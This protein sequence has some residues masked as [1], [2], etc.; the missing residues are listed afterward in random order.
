M[1]RRLEGSIAA[2]VAAILLANA[3]FASPPGAIIS[4]QASLDYTNV[5]GL[6]VTI[7]SNI[8]ELTTAVVRSPANVELTRVVG[9]GSGDYQETTGP[10]ACFQGGSFVTLAD[11]TLIGG[12]TIDPT[13][14]QDVSPTSAYNLG[15]AAFIRLADTDQNL[16]FQVIDYAVVTVENAASGDSEIIRLAETGPDTGVFAGY[17]PTSGGAAVSGDC[18]LQVQSNSTLTVDYADP[19][20]ATDTASVSATIDPVQRVFESRT[21]TLVDG[22][23]IELVDA[24]TGLPAL[25]YGNDGV[26]QFPSLIVS[27]GSTVDSGGTSYVFGN[28]EY[29]FPVVPD[30]DYRLIVT[31]PSDYTA[32]S[33]ADINDLQ[34]LPGAPFALE[35]GSF[36]AAFS[37][38]GDLSFALDIPVD[39]QA[40]A[41]FLQKRT[42]TTSAAPG[43]FV[44]YELVLENASVSGLANN[45]QIFDDLPAGVRLV[46]GSVRIDDAS[47]AD[48]VISADLSQLE[49]NIASLD[50]A[51]R[52]SIFYV[53]E[54]IGG[55]RDQELINR[56]T[57]FA[58]GGLIS[59]EATA[60][61]RLKE[62]LFRSTGTI[63]GRIVE[64][65]CRQES[66]SEDQGVEN[67]RVYLEDGRY[68]VSD[69]GGRFHFEG[70]EP[71]T[72]VAQ[73]DTFTV[74]AYFDVIGCD[75]SPGFAGNVTSQFVKL[76]RGSLLR[77]DFYLKRKP[78]PEGRIDLE[79]RNLGTDSA[80]EVAYELTLNG[81]GNVDIQ[82]IDLMFLLPDGV[83]YQ[84]GS[85]R[86]DGQ[87]HGDPRVSGTMLS[88]AVDDKF[89][90]WTS[91]VRFVAVIDSDVDGELTTKAMAKFDSPIAAGQET[92]VAE[93]RMSREPAETKNEGYVLDLKFA[94]LSDELSAGDKVKL[95]RLIADWKG[96]SDIRIGAIGHSD[97][98]RIAPRNRHL[99]ADNYA[100]SEAR[101][102]AAARYLADALDIPRDNMQIAGRGPDEPLASNATAAGRQANRRVEMVLSGV[103]PSK[104]SFLEVTQE[105]S[106]TKVT[107]T[108]G[109]IP[110][111]EQ[112]RRAREASQ[113][114]VDAGLPTSQIEPP[115]DT[116]KPGVALLLPERGFQPAIPAT[117]VSVQHAP[118][119]SVKIYINDAPINPLSFDVMG[120][121]A[122]RTVAV[123]RWK[124]V[125]LEDGN[126]EIRV[127]VSNA[128]GSRAKS[129]TRDVY[130]SGPAVR[131][132]FVEELSTLTA[133]GKTR[134]VIAVRLFDRAGK[135][136][137][138]GTVG[139]YRVDAPYRSI[140]DVENDRKNELVS[141]GPREPVY[142]VGK[143]GIALIELEP[144]TQSGEVTL[145]LKFER[146]REQQMRAWLKPAAR[147]WIL[148][149]FAEG[150]AA[151]N[152]L[153]KNA[154]LAM[155]AGFEDEYVDEGRVA[156]F[157]K[158]SIK[159]EYLMTI[160][161]DSDR[162][163]SKSRN[164]FETEVDPNA[165]YALYAD[166]SEQRFEAPSQRKLYVK[167][168]RNQF[169]AL[170]GDM[171]TGLSITDLARYER[172]FNGFKS[173]F[174]GDNVGYTVFAAE[175][176][177]GF[178][179]DELRGDGTSGLYR[180][181]RTP[182]IVSSEQVRIEV[183]DRFDSG[184]VLSETKLSRFVDYNLDTLNGTLFFK[185]PVP[186]RDLDFNP[187]FIVVEYESVSNADEDLIAGGRISVKSDND[188]FEVGATHVTDETAGAEADLSGVDMR[189][190]INPETLLKVE[191]A[192]SNSIDAGV[193]LEGTAH[194]VE[195][196]HNGEN[197]D[198]RAYIREVEDDFGLG[199]QSASDKGFRRLGVEA[200]GRISER[201][202]YEGEAGWQQNLSTE[203]IR[204]LASARLRYERESFSAFAGMLH[205]A[206]KFD[207]GEDRVSDI[208]QL[209]ISKKLFGGKLNL[210]ASGSS[211]LSGETENSDFPTSF[212]V[213]ADYSVRKGV[214][215]VAEYE[216][217]SG[218]GI[219]ATMTRVGVKANPWSRTQINTFVTNE[220]SE[221]GPRLFANV[222]LVQGFQLSERW[223]LDFGVDQSNT[224][225]DST[226]R[227]F[228]PD[229]DLVSGS[230]NED[231]LAV[232]AG[233]MYTADVWSANSR[234]EHRNSDTE[235]RTSLLMGWYREPTVGH[236][237]SAGLTIL[238]SDNVSGSEL[239]AADLKVGWAYRKANSR[240][241]FLNRTDLT[242]EDSLTGT[243]NLNS[244]RVVN[245]FNANRRYG[246]SMQLSLQYAF[247]YVR[248]EFDNDGYNGFT[249]LIGVDLRRGMR[250]RWDVGLYTSIYHSYQSSVI[251]Y[252]VGVDVGYQLRD[253]MWLTLGYNAA[254]FHD[255]DFSSARYTAQGPYLRFSI[256]ADQAILKSIAGR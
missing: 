214:D 58:D 83:R 234:L 160:A 108:K 96:V 218:S 190:Q 138:A 251:D 26:S 216:D 189:W 206:D 150:T 228:D 240:W 60:M 151:Y 130:Y 142:R 51:E 221:F 62:D 132:E 73:L 111:E 155:E 78:R 201:W 207:D 113:V 45:V 21:G 230:N 169:N 177:Q 28:G 63:L 87:D 241:S 114:D 20:D 213:G 37:K 184:Q 176:N 50:V 56:A 134:P 107:P 40:S 219:D 223:S 104:P 131:G 210:R 12:S 3:A 172:R 246:A 232:F 10:S 82:N 140:W 89:G 192:Q 48:P 129:I 103:R 27:G 202:S 71:G 154:S 209:G 49:F 165:L 55:E 123:S 162:D 149:G 9:A 242:F 61:I 200:R 197:V 65:D 215:L 183:R 115:I 238:T 222:G 208:G 8:V 31:P 33:S 252:G 136:S 32:P 119:Q 211:A 227:V 225:S 188:A 212:V 205:A 23:E 125:A 224:L 120:L 22:A 91:Q 244:W 99:F 41:L 204:N 64:G 247:K 152:S 135:P 100:L 53:V 122:S 124:G 180:L 79:L 175:S 146:E 72:H 198:V 249:D 54:I 185:R 159:G 173:E 182:I 84:P 254:G 139:A 163:R 231:F 199:Y 29:R 217:A 256:K 117:K 24:A 145:N 179:R 35:P 167:L 157:A 194:S 76:S 164:R 156:F 4:N 144:T 248:S 25:V 44:R 195:L 36:G 46:P 34:I 85:M 6:N 94:I 220:I 93:T 18:V 239:T 118:S 102:T 80:E 229:R 161:Y 203:D 30:G 69:A 226:A 66:F 11:P 47:A 236:G 245:N 191:F 171:N 74:P 158:G 109:A 147:D 121:N 196:E 133:D 178:H 15:E 77:A 42:T 92:P 253:N 57:A 88:M 101:A 2:I 7:T 186:S 38:S 90:N 98:Q 106:G 233:A 153:S 59:N 1:K 148:V 235:E 181:S 170:F 14:V 112:E 166:T 43:D 126:N 174:R 237:L 17:V 86:V 116:L 5:G 128:D 75:E 68:A 193:E 243:V 255:S 187:V 137:R 127:I 52:T 81:T 16:D 13:A 143:D 168:E 67:I 39:P 141:I 19:A 70:I 97:S 95:D 250:D 110:G 105:S